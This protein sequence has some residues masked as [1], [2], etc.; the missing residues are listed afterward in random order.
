M[1]VFFLENSQ[2]LENINS[3]KLLRRFTVNIE[4]LFAFLM[5]D[6]GLSYRYQ[7]FDNCFGGGWTAQTYSFYN[8]SGCFTIHF[9]LQKNELDFY[10]ASRFSTKR[11]ELCEKMVDVSSIEPEIWNKHTKI[12]VFNRPFFWWNSNKI[13]SVFAESLK[14]HLAKNKDFFGIRV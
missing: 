14:V 7:K 5:K 1:A 2:S 3:L 13:L 12:W 8:D 6:Y 11:E 10:R 4:E 9:L